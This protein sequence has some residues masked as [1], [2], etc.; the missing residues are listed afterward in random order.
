M[1]IVNRM[2]IEIDRLTDAIRALEDRV[3]ELELREP[4]QHDGAIGFEV[5]AS[6]DFDEDAPEYKGAEF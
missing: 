5:D 3:R 2:L 1:G 4:R 6:D